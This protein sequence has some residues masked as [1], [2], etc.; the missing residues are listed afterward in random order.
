MPSE[1]KA[2][3]KRGRSLAGDG[4]F[5]PDPIVAFVAH[6]PKSAEAAPIRTLP[7]LYA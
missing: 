5:V 4:W 7:W 1:F 2:S 3:R 6:L